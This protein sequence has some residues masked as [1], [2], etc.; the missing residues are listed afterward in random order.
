MRDKARKV[1][2]PVRTM[3]TG[4]LFKVMATAPFTLASAGK[5]PTLIEPL[6]GG[7][8]AMKSPPSPHAASISAAAA[9]VA[10]ETKVRR[11]T[12]HLQNSAIFTLPEPLQGSLKRKCNL[13]KQR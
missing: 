11:S 9:S 4:V 5:S 12:S 7:G 1:V 2:V 6:S 10:C 13:V 8:P 3:A